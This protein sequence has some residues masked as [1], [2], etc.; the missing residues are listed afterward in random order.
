M[1]VMNVE[2]EDQGGSP[3]NV[4]TAGR[5]TTDQTATTASLQH[6]SLQDFEIDD[7]LS[8]VDNE[9][10]FFRAIRASAVERAAERGRNVFQTSGGRSSTGLRQYNAFIRGKMPTE[11]Y[12]VDQTFADQYRGYQVGE[13]FIPI[14]PIKIAMWLKDLSNTRHISFGTAK[15]YVFSILDEALR[16]FNSGYT[17]G[18]G[19]PVKCSE[20]WWNHVAISTVLESF[21]ENDASREI[22]NI[23]RDPVP[24]YDRPRVLRALVAHLRNS[25]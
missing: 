23:A 15:N 5:E 12:I 3:N 4:G 13:E 19:K 16:Q 20:T 7:N 9:E 14:T 8:I 2:N 1:N 22:A 6:A 24:R 11:V 25:T 18:F 21:I 17:T 10:K